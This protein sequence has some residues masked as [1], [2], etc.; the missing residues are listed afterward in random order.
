MVVIDNYKYL[1][2]KE[3]Y[4]SLELNK[5]EDNLSNVKIKPL[6]VVST[7][8]Y[9]IISN[10]FF[11][12]NDA[13]ISNLNDEQLRKLN[14]Y[15]SRKI[16]E[17]SDQELEEAKQFIKD[18]YRLILFPTQKG[19]YVYYGPA[20]DEYV[21]PSDAIAIG[22][23]YDAFEDGEDFEIE[24]NVA[25]VVNYI[26]FQLSKKIGDKVSVIPFNQLTLDNKLNGFAK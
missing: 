3:I 5:V 15:F 26:Q 17:L 7:D 8:G 1:F 11:L 6:T 21:S 20:S 2:F 9:D 19:K 14:Y 16:D 12:L 25:D 10:Y 4:K 18:T 13:N 24:N 22:L 23:Y